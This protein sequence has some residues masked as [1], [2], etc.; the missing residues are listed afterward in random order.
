MDIATL[1]GI[2]SAFGLVIFAIIMG[3]GISLFINLPSLMIVLG[4]TFGATMINYPI[5]DVLGALK[6]VKNVFLSKPASLNEV[7]GK[8]VE[9][10]GKARREGILSLE[11]NAKTIRDDFF[12]KG[13]QLSVDGVEPQS[14]KEILD[15][16]IN[17]LRDRH[18]LGAEIF[19][20]MGAFAPALGMI[21]TLIG[22]VQ[23]LQSMDDPNSIGPAMAV[24]LL[25]TFY[26][27]MLSNLVCLPVAG[28]L[29]TRSKEEIIT[30]EMIVQGIISLSRGDN[31][32]ILEHK[33]MSFLAPK[34]R[35]RTFK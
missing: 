32:R 19:Q 29:R 22:L 27:S 10:A 8:F 26:G 13:I 34:L 30:K 21:G 14:I 18:Q 31:P 28:K 15:T 1:L 2:A 35:E 5:R 12:R 7:V 3:G 23:M 17:F 6:V 11:S 4:G 33:L 20:T 9:F 24:A 25:T 16:E